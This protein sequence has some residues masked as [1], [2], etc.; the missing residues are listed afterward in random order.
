[1]DKQDGLRYDYLLISRADLEIFLGS[2]TK[3][4]PDPS[5]DFLTCYF[6]A[7]APVKS[8]HDSSVQNYVSELE[9]RV[10]GRSS[11]GV[12]SCSQ[13]HSQG[14]GVKWRT[15][16]WLKVVA[17]DKE[18]VVYLLIIFHKIYFSSYY[19]PS[20]IHKLCPAG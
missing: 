13:G 10:T 14:L 20:A 11:C 9:F 17:L 2:I 3:S 16:E 18:Q 12:L 19:V 8:I 6:S 1:M 15:Q 7:D 4:K 5:A